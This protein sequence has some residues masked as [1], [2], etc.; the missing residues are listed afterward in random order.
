[1]IHDLS[2]SMAPLRY[3]SRRAYMGPPPSNLPALILGALTLFGVVGLF[4]DIAS[5]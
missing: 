5:L 4:V 2:P 3:F 1:M